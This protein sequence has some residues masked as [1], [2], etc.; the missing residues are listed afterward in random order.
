MDYSD[1]ECQNMFTFNQC[2][3]MRQAI[4]RY[5]GQLVSSE[6]L[7]LTG[8]TET[9]ISEP[10]KDE[11]IVYPNPVSDVLLVYADFEDDDPVS[12]ELYDYSGRLVVKEEEAGVGRGAIPI[13]VSTLTMGSYHLLVRMANR[14]H[15]Q[16][17]IVAK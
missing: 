6:N 9:L 16:T 13:D 2:Q 17:I 8:C 12:I 7:A 3:R 5:R 15:R 11:F 4:T 14:Y 1:D 10:S